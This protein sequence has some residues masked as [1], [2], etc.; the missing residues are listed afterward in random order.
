[1][2]A[3]LFAP[4]DLD[5]L[6]GTT[7]T[8]RNADS[9]THTVTE[10]ED[11]FDSGFVRPGG[12]VRAGRSRS[13]ARS[14]TTAR[15]TASCAGPCTCSRSCCEGPTSR[16]RRETG[17]A[18]GLRARRR[19]PRSCSSASRPARRDR[20]GASRARSRRR[21]ASP[22]SAPEPRAYRVR[23]GS[24]SSPLVRVRV[25]PHVTIARARRSDR[26]RALAR[27]RREPGRAPG[28]R[29]R[30]V[31]LRHRRSRTAGRVVS[32]GDPLRRRA[33]ARTSV[34]SFAAARA[35]A[36]ASA[37]RS[38]SARADLASQRVRTDSPRTPGAGGPRG[39]R[40]RR[41]PAG[42]RRGSGGPIC[43][44]GARCA[45]SSSSTPAGSISPP[46]CSPRTRG[47]YA[48]RSPL[49]GSGSTRTPSSTCTAPVT[50]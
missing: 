45:R 15:S 20:R 29:P 10:D 24:A 46:S 47:R 48:T 35:G 11:E 17:A 49:T 28:L 1:M 32:G 8:W 13:R 39:G 36:T 18:G 40:A 44:T 19:G 26:R 42:A 3:K 22:C 43:A 5:V 16:S 9:T 37:V 31:R 6:V 2:P 14:C 4:R 7:V 23:A 25:T 27:P 30:E 38:S 41:R 50:V 21:F 33:A 34:P 12:D